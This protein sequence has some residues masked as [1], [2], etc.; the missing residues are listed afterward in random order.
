[1]YPR[2]RIKSTLIT[3]T[4]IMLTVL[5]PAH[6]E[7][8]AV[9]QAYEINAAQVDRWPL[10][11]TGSLV[12]RACNSCDSVT[13][14]VDAATRYRLGMSGAEVSRD[15]LVS[16]QATLRDRK[17][18]PVYVFYRPQDGIATRVVLDVDKN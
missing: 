3:T 9:E 1:M 17:S 6:A 10:G 16:L 13:L 11:D 8:V 4:A 5:L 7:L 14:R 12:L 2:E 18:T 15:E